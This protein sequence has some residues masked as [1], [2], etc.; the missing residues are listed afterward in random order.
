MNSWFLPKRVLWIYW[1]ERYL[2]DGDG[3]EKFMFL[4]RK[5]KMYHYAI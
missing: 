3:I 2:D 4:D 1:N 5:C